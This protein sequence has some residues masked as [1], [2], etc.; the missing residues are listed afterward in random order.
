[1]AKTTRRIGVRALPWLTTGA[2]SR[3]R[4]I[5]PPGTG[6]ARRPAEVEIGAVE[7]FE[8]GRGVARALGGLLAQEVEGQGLEDLRDGLGEAF[9]GGLRWRV[10]V[11]AADLDEG[12]AL[13]D[14]RA[15]DEEV[16]RCPE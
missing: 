10:Y 7:P 16:G 4:S 6:G 11:V 3:P 2:K 15:G 12:G 14:R 1:M 13:E 9:G 5:L 8:D